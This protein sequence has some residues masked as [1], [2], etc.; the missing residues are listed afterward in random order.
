MRIA[1]FIAGAAMIASAFA[2]PAFAGE[3]GS[4]LKPIYTPPPTY[5]HTPPPAPTYAPAPTQSYSKSYSHSSTTSA[6][7]RNQQQY[8][9]LVA[10]PPPPPRVVYRQV[11][12]TTTYTRPTTTYHPPAQPTCGYATTTCRT[13]APHPAPP[14]PPPPPVSNCHYQAAPQGYPCG[15]QYQPP[16]YIGLDTCGD[17]VIKRLSNTR[18]G[19]RRYSVCYSDLKHLTEYD[20]NM[21]LLERMEK[22]A[23]KACRD[24]RSISYGL[25]A[26][27][28][29]E[30]ES[31]EQSVYDA[32]VRGLVE[33][34]NIK[35][36]KRSPKV[37]VGKP[38]YY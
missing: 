9:R 10:T 19:Q 5:S 24:H 31:L 33:A 7:V 38:Q 4:S 29:C 23:D 22:A 12:P 13:P 35:Y 17:D 25:S 11:Q 37:H 8:N 2:M 27:R 26:R 21:I 14:P 6:D 15:P 32:P 16:A 1:R 36:N 20:R 28:D 34:Y 30:E 18:D 3:P